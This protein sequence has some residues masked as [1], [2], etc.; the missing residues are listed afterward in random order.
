M[1]A[2]HS[3]K[4]ARN[5]RKLAEFVHEFVVPKPRPGGAGVLDENVHTRPVGILAEDPCG[6]GA[7]RHDG[8]QAARTQGGSQ[9]VHESP[10]HETLQG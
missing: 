8:H 5:E 10:G 4:R 9:R 7:A 1:G 3:V 6:I 2:S